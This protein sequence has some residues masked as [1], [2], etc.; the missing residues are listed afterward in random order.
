MQVVPEALESVAPV[1]PK[2]KRVHVKPVQAP[3]VVSS[4]TNRLADLQAAMLKSAENIERLEYI[5]AGLEHLQVQ[6]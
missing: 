1:S 5:I 2:I 4:V 3:V 6:A